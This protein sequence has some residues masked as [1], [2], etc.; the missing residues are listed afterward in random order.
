MK[1]IV[2]IRS[3]LTDIHFKIKDIGYLGKLLKLG[4]IIYLARDHIKEEYR[5]VKLGKPKKK[6]LHHLLQILPKTNTITYI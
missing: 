2:V 6:Q 3:Y 1:K 5:F 4:F